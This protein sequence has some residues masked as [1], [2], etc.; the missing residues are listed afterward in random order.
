MRAGARILPGE[1]M[2][3]GELT[4]RRWAADD[5]AALV[6]AVAASREHLRPWMPWASG[7]Q[8][9]AEQ[10]RG[11]IERWNHA[12]RAGGDAVYGIFVAGR[13]AG[14]CGLHRRLGPDGLEMGYWLHVDFT[15]RGVMTVAATLLTE[16]AFTV[17]E[18]ELVE[19][20]H[21]AANEPSGGVPRRLGYTLVEQVV[22]EPQTPAELG[23][24]L[25][26][27]ITRTQ[28]AQRPAGCSTSSNVARWAAEGVAICSTPPPPPQLS[29]SPP[30]S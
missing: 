15:G 5:A 12:W 14:G 24:E 25:R 13:V 8:D 22:R 10:R 6:A 30:D 26:W 2:S 3:A 16:A 1:A 21:D 19:I 17:P 20:H 4:V 27:R 11:R 18:V 23:V 9:T 7:V 29:C 28:W